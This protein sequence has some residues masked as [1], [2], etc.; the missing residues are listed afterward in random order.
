MCTIVVARC[1]ALSAMSEPIT[2]ENP[3]AR[4]PGCWRIYAAFI[5]W[6]YVRAAN[7]AGHAD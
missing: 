2:F 7:G 6:L 5:G 3:S 1:D 4:R